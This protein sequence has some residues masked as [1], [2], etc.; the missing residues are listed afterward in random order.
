M[1]S[2]TLRAQSCRPAVVQKSRIMTM[3]L[4]FDKSGA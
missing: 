3:A 4:A 2:W 1:A